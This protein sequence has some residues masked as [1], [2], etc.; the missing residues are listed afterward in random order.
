MRYMHTVFA[1][2]GAVVAELV[3][4][5]L[6]DLWENGSPDVFLEPK[7]IYVVQGNRPAAFNPE[8][9]QVRLNLGIDACGSIDFH[10][11]GSG[12][13]LRVTARFN[14][15]SVTFE[16]FLTSILGIIDRNN[17]NLQTMGEG[18]GC[19]KFLFDEMQVNAQ[20]AYGILCFDN[21]TQEY[22]TVVQEGTPPLHV[23]LALKAHESKEYSRHAL[24]YAVDH[25]A[26][27]QIERD[28]DGR[29]T[30][31]SV[32]NITLPEINFEALEECL[33]SGKVVDLNRYRA[34]RSRPRVY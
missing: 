3:R 17:N 33:A 26:T 29:E 31:V 34:Q 12:T 16:F 14:Q 15:Q 18:G 7:N 19:F 2:N 24:R 1:H 11:E 25:P 32:T 6:D 22:L 4:K 20:N 9:Q 27:V 28:A 23:E 30:A 5:K 8:L 21:V 10:G 13:C